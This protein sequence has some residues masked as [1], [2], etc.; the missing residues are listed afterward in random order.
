MNQSSTQVHL[1]RFPIRY[2]SDSEKTVNSYSYSFKESPERG[3]EYAA[4]SKITWNIGKATGVRF[5]STIVTKHP[6]AES[7]LEGENWTLQPQGERLLDPGSSP[8]RLVLEQLERKSLFNA[9]KFGRI[10]QKVARYATGGFIWWKQDQIVLNQSGWEVH[11]GVHVDLEIH[12]SGVIFIEVDS[13]YKFYTEWTLAQ[14]LEDFPELPITWVRNTYDDR[15]WKYRRTSNENPESL[16]IK[17]LGTTL[18]DYHR[19]LKSGKATESEISNAQVVYVWDQ[20]NREV[21]HLSTR[22]KSSMTMEMLSHLSDQ[23]QTQAKKVF[24][25]IKE[26]TNQRFAKGEKVA[27]WLAKNIYQQT[28]KPP[29]AQKTP[30]IL[31]RKNSSILLTRLGRVAKPAQSLNQ[32]CFKTGE[33]KFGCLDLVG[34][35]LWPQVIRNKLLQVAQKSGV[36]IELEKPRRGI[37]LPETALARDQFWQDWANQGTKTVLVVTNWLQNSEKTRLCREALKANIALQFM[38]P[39]FKPDNYRAVNII[40]GM[41]VR[42]A[43]QPVGLEPLTSKYAADLVIGFDAGTN[44]LLHFGTS[45]FSICGNGQ[46]LGWELPEAQLGE[47]LSSQLV[48]NTVNNIINRFKQLEHRHPNRILILRDGLVQCEEFDDTVSD[49]LSEN[50]AVD[51]LGVR[52][53]GA[54]RMAISNSNTGILTDAPP[55]TVT[56]SQDGNLFRLVSST[57]KAGGSCLLYTSPSP[58]D[59][60]Q[61]RMPSSA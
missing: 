44:G 42:A 57:A 32:G 12:P 50:I 23:G 37:S 17:G 16:I 20:K 3:Q 13:H 43:W 47:K 7:Y 27:A 59:K 33:Q 35:G 49:L 6:I 1:N 24:Q 25:Q 8:E 45:A 61:S 19:N 29:Q 39:M 2:L 51:L 30:G 48:Q 40:L 38:L 14:W 9:L 60:R 46:S 21:A 10:R 55:G 22:L 58:R 28:T 26:K 31:L 5:G 18:A 34:N 53:S 11:H 15:T 56:L 54:G 41:L 4:V 52:K 36:D